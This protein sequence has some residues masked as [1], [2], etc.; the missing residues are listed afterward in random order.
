MIL[1]GTRRVNG[2]RLAVVF[3]APRYHRD[4]TI[5]AAL[6]MYHDG[7]SIP[8]IGQA[9]KVPKDTVSNWVRITGFS[10]TRTKGLQARWK[11]GIHRSDWKGG[12]NAGGYRKVHREGKLFSEHRLVMESILGRAL[13]T[14]E[15]V[16]H[17]NGDRVDNRP[18]NLELWTLRRS[19][20]GQRV[21]DRVQD[22]L[23]TLARYS[24]EFV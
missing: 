23:E 15:T 9:L 24:G 22:A 21:Q 5:S 12:I 13:Q 7:I 18:E 16:H 1:R 8:L 6:S 19:P 17:K 3:R 10:R 20:P 14:D 2:R 4:E 11:L